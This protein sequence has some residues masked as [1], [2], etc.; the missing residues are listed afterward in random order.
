MLKEGPQHIGTALD[1]GNTME[2]QKWQGPYPQAV[3]FLMMGQT[4]TSMQMIYNIIIYEI[5]IGRMKK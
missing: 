4:K 2:T 1:F 5:V 3:Y